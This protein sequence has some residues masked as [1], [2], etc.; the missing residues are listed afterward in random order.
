[1]VIDLL[2]NFLKTVT[3]VYASPNR[4]LDAQLELCS[5]S[6]TSVSDPLRRPSAN[7]STTEAP[8]NALD[9]LQSSLRAWFV[10][11]PLWSSVA[12]RVMRDVILWSSAGIVQPL[13]AC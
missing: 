7:V 12:A 6:S 5:M 1:M 2:E 11:G 9:P 3:P 13:D 10:V 4:L 8:I